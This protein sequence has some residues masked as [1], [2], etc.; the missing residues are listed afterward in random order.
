MESKG[1]FSVIF[2]QNLNNPITL[3]KN[4]LST[5]ATTKWHKL[6]GFQFTQGVAIYRYSI[7]LF[8]KNWKMLPKT[9]ADQASFFYTVQ[10][11]WIKRFVVLRK[12]LFFVRQPLKNR[13]YK[14]KTID[15][16]SITN[17]C[18]NKDW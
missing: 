9:I 13:K 5:N 17:N 3:H 18:G 2:L 16:E 10:M 4:L 11:S 7:K 6:F 12:H 14:K 15:I 8:S 1:I